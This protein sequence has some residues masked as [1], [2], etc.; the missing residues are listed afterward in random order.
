MQN[1]RDLWEQQRQ[2][3]EQTVSRLKSD[4]D[5]CTGTVSAVESAV[6]Q[7]GRGLQ[8]TLT[9]VLTKSRS[10]EGNWVNSNK[11][12]TSSEMKLTPSQ[13]E[14]TAPTSSSGKFMI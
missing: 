5:S 9:N 8:S 4:L 1:E 12:N 7:G 11:S 13:E 3:L 10:L 2:E 14:D 6:T